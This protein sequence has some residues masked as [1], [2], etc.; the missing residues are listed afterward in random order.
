MKE[1]RRKDEAGTAE[2]NNAEVLDNNECN[3][4]LLDVTIDDIDDDAAVGDDA[5]KEDGHNDSALER[6]R[7]Q[8]HRT[9]CS[10]CL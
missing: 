6:L 4:A 10:D 8:K 1:R 2:V 9:R 5:D 3:N 7:E